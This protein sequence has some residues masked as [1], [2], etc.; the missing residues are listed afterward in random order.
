MRENH[1]AAY[2]AGALHHSRGKRSSC[3]RA[4][5]QLL[6]CDDAMLR[7]EDST[8]KTS[9]S[10]GERKA[11]YRALLAATTTHFGKSF[12]LRHGAN[13]RLL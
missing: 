8:T 12:L 4:A 5:E 13:S 9:C 11:Q 1:A 6:V 7:V 2:A 10:P 3:Q